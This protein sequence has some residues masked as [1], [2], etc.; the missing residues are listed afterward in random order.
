MISNNF[1]PISNLILLIFLIFEGP[2]ERPE[3]STVLR[4][5]TDRV[6]TEAS[7]SVKRRS[8]DGSWVDG[9]IRGE[10]CVATGAAANALW[11]LG[12]VR[13]IESNHCGTEF[14]GWSHRVPRW[15]Q[16]SSKVQFRGGSNPGQCRSHRVPGLEQHRSKVGAIQ[17]QGRST[18]FQ[19]AIRGIY[20]SQRWPTLVNPTT[21]GVGTRVRQRQ[22]RATPALQDEQ[23]TLVVIA[24]TTVMQRD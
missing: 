2:R 11:R 20:S 3:R 4:H 16:S 12:L 10:Y 15:D 5:R 22:S 8:N 19:V 24:R 18:T 9:V 21:L 13:G 23:S 7:C 14:Q 6:S 1:R 17:S